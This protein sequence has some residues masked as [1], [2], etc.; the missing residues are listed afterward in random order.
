MSSP[1]PLDSVIAVSKIFDHDK[2]IVPSE[3]REELH[4]SNGDKVVWYKKGDEICIRKKGGPFY[5]TTTAAS[6]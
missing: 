6:V 4:I 2:V 3:V 1:N 5:K